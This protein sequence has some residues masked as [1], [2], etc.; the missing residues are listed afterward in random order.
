MVDTVS[1]ET[2]EEK[3][4]T[5]RKSIV[6]NR[7]KECLK[8]DVEVNEKHIIYFMNSLRNLLELD[9]PKS[10]HKKFFTLNFF[11]NWCLHIKMD[12]KD[13]EN[14]VIASEKDFSEINEI[15]TKKGLDVLEE[16]EK[17]LSYVTFINQELLYLHKLRE[18]ISIIF[19]ENS[20]STELIENNEW[21]AKIRKKLIEAL[22]S[23]PHIISNE[24][25]LVKFLV[26][27]QDPSMEKVNPETYVGSVKIF[28][29]DGDVMD[30]SAMDGTNRN[31]G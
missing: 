13:Y 6:L 20:I 2:P 9:H 29:S 5:Q 12:K 25:S 18:Q 30:M 19:K 23:F 31:T 22:D 10:R 24:N 3:Y 4:L 21:W 7:I 15:R 27:E 26:M 11:T 16:K 14:I 8:S 1:E 17:K 28:F